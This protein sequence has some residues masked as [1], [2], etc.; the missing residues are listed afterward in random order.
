MTALAINLLGGW[1][2]RS[3]DGSPIALSSRKAQALLAVLALPAGR[4]YHRDSLATLLWG[5]TADEQARASLRQAILAIRRA[6]APIGGALLIDGEMIALDLAQVSVDVARFE[7]K[8]AEGTAAA[9]AEAASLYRGPLVDGLSVRTSAF[10]EWLEIGRA[11][12]RGRV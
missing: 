10:E 4:A 6:F 3:A 5:E 2:L 11:S 8:L 9:L 7:A 12:W 1:D